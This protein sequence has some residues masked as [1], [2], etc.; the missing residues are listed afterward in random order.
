MFKSL[1]E[2]SSV[3]LRCIA[4][5]DKSELELVPDPGMFIFFRKGTRAG[6]SYGS[7]R[8]SK[9][10]KK[11]FKSYDPKQESKHIIYSDARN[12]YGYAMSK[13]LPT[14]GFKWINHNDFDL[15]RYISNSSEGC[16]FEEDLEYPKELPELYNNYP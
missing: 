1:F 16:V 12:L 5:Y 15:N 4:Q 13:F 6:V 2:R 14:K 7:N 8:Y 3:K 11:Y 10:N 9:T